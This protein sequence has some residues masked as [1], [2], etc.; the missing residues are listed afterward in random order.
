MSQPEVRRKT[1]E[2]RL[3][4]FSNLYIDTEPKPIRGDHRLRRDYL[5]VMDGV[6]YQDGE[7]ICFDDVYMIND[8]ETLSSTDKHAIIS[9]WTYMIK[10]MREGLDPTDNNLGIL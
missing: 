4:G 3:D 7:K 10:K 6:L 9:S 2:N 1:I 8:T 5:R